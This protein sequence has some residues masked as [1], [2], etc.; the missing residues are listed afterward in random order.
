MYPRVLLLT[1]SFLFVG[2]ASHAVYAL[3]EADAQVLMKKSNC[4]KCHSIDKEKVGPA[5]KEIARKYQDKADAEQKL[6]T[7][8]STN[9]KVK[10]D[11]KE[12][13]HES[14]K[15]QNEADIRSVVRWILA[16]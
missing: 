7:H 9:P 1:G 16:R 11:G 4:F 5:F 14:L 6:Y 3:G 8:L 10:I 12:E 15:T 13:Q 2:L